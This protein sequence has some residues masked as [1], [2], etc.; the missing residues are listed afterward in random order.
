MQLRIRIL[1]ANSRQTHVLLS[2]ELDL[3]TVS[4]LNVVLDRIAQTNTR[5]LI[6]DLSELSYLGSV[7]VGIIIRISDTLAETGRQLVLTGAQGP[8]K[9]VLQLLGLYYLVRQADA[10]HARNMT[11]T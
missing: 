9:V 6:L 1:C 5:E 8:V 3:E 11:A 2:G 7:G 10:P 4:Q